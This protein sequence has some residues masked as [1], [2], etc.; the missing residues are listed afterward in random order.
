MRL[1]SPMVSAE[2]KLRYFNARIAK[3]KKRLADFIASLPSPSLK[4]LLGD[5]YYKLVSQ[6]STGYHTRRI[7]ALRAIDKARGLSPVFRGSKYDAEIRK[8]AKQGKTGRQIASKLGLKT[9]WVYQ[10]GSKV[11]IRFQSGLCKVGHTTRYL[12]LVHNGKRWCPDCFEI[13]HPGL[14]DGRVDKDD[15]DNYE[16]VRAA[17]VLWLGKMLDICNMT[18]RREI[19][20]KELV[21]W[22]ASV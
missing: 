4:V 9:A 7:K 14:Y 5:K 6:A 8:L 18:Y 19:I 11:D 2:Q 16:S 17:T 13:A 20:K 15:D 12:K 1:R 3:E 10:R 21:S 22:G